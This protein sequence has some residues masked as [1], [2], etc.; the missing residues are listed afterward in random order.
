MNLLRRLSLMVITGFIGLTAIATPLTLAQNDPASNPASGLRVSPT[1][2]ELTVAPGTSEVARFTVTNVT[3]GSIIVKS[4]VNDFT[5]NQDGSINLQADDA[6]QSP[7]SIKPFVTLPGDVPLASG[8]SYDAA[9]PVDVSNGT[10]PGAY[11]GAVLFQ[12]VPVRVDGGD[13]G[14]VAL[15][16]SVGTIILVQV[17]GDITEQMQLVS[18][19]AG[20]EVKTGEDATEVRTSTL[21][22]QPP[23]KIQ[24]TVKNVGN[25]FLKPFGKVTVKDM[26]GNEVY[27]YELNN[28]DPRG[29]V[30]PNTE[31]TF[32]NDLENIGSFGRYTIVSGVTYGDGGDILTQ[33]S[34]FW[35]IP[36]W[37]VLVFAAVVILIVAGIV[38]LVRKFKKRNK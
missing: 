5:S 21:F 4:E 35:V 28:T 26:R 33:E 30:L 36:F 27:S 11:Y 31:R 9:I 3:G 37:A 12:A 19:R 24:I 17:P 8:E 7:S 13:S 20:R 18:M 6:E 16:G 2:A 34:T 32:T 22:N 29:N 15:S 10:A 14:Q 25:S 23:T 38:F 1:R